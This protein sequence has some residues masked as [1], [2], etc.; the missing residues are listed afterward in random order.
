M[1]Q[2]MLIDPAISARLER[3]ECKLDALLS[4]L[5]DEQEPKDDPR[6]SLDQGVLDLGSDWGQ[7]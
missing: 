7:L 3:I 6:A 2:H 5:A 1:I 4:A